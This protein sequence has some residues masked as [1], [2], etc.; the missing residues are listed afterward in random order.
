MSH[1]YFHFLERRARIVAARAEARP[2]STYRLHWCAFVALAGLALSA[3][4]TRADEAPDSAGGPAAAAE[5][6]DWRFDLAAYGWLTDIT[7]HAS[8]GDVTLDVDPQLFKDIVDNLDGALMG[9]VEARY[10]ER[11]IVSLD[12][13][14]AQLSDHIETGPF[15]VGF[16]PRTFEVAGRA[17]S[18]TLPVETRIGTLEVPL[19]V[20]PGVLRIDVPRV[21][22][23]IGPF[24]VDLKQLMIQARA[25]VGYRLLDVPALELLGHD[26]TD[27]PRRVSVDV[28]AGLRYWY[29]KAEVDVDSPPI[30]IPPFN[31]RSSISGGSVDARFRVPTDAI[32]LPTVRLPDVQFGGSTFGGTN[33]HEEESTWWIDP[34][35]GLRARA[36]LTE[37]VSLTLAGNIGGFDI[38]S[39]SQFSWEAIA[40]LTL[41]LSD[42]TSLAAG[43]RG[44]GINR[45]KSD[46]SVDIVMHGPLIGLLFAF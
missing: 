17:F 36:D 27:D 18:T 11:W 23:S 42:R 7:G 6:G 10:R 34:L 44:I 38:G 25:S 5:P 30:K 19:R 15:S 32:A 31:V 35:I 29:V 45:G 4:A 3:D 39:A 1:E 28:L 26:E 14:G 20:D 41:R 46:V 33:I 9:A 12:L 16:G 37:S 13:F 43:Y 21:A 22:T 40:F 24:D 2:L 8:V